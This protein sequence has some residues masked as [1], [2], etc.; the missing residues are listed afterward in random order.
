M[1]TLKKIWYSF[2]IQII[3]V[4]LKYDFLLLSVW[5]FFALLISGALFKSMGFHYLFLEPEYLGIVNFRSFFITGLAFGVFF[6]TWNMASYSLQSFRFP[7][8]A[9]LKTPF[10]HYCLNNFIIPTGFFLLYN[11]Y[12]YKINYNEEAVGTEIITFYEGLLAGFLICLFIIAPYLYF[13]NKNIRQI[14]H[15]SKIK[16]KYKT[17]STPEEMLT[18]QNDQNSWP[19]D[20]YLST[21]LL[22]RAVRRVDH[23]SQDLLKAVFRQNHLNNF[24]VQISLIVI[25]LLLGYLVEVPVF[26]FPPAFGL[27]IGGSLLVMFV[28][29][30]NYWISGWSFFVLIFSLIII[31]RLS[32]YDALFPKNKMYGIDYTIAPKEYS[33]ATINEDLTPQ[34]IKS[35]IKSGIKLLKNR[36]KNIKEKYPYDKPKMVIIGLSGGGS[37]AAYW[38]MN[39]LQKADSL[40]N[41]RLLDQTFLITGA[42]GGMFAGAYLRELYLRKEVGDPLN[43]WDPKWAENIGKDKLNALCSMFLTN[44]LL[45]PQHEF[46]Y[47]GFTYTKDRGYAFEADFNQDTNYLLNK[48]IGEYTDDEMNGLIPM[49]V[50][51]PMIINDN[52][53]LFISSQPVSYLSRPLLPGTYHSVPNI[54]TDGIEF[55]RFFD[56]YCANDILMTTALR[57]NAT[58]PIIFPPVFLPTDPPVRVMDAGMRDNFGYECVHRYVSAYQDWI[59]ENIDQVVWIEIRY[60]EKLEEIVKF[61]P[62]FIDRF[63]IPINQ[64]YDNTAQMIDFYND[65]TTTAITDILD[66]RIEKISFDL[67]PVGKKERVS[68]SFHLTDKEKREV[69]DAITNPNN[70]R[71]MIRLL[72]LL[73]D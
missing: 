39:V 38:T 22:P 37:A 3:I 31:D 55:G 16:K 23:Y 17:L 1:N 32:G 29:M 40:L 64:N 42:S 51:S 13:T 19:V 68:M 21:S 67:K 34:I 26:Q 50:I 63:S 30:I 43:I 62:G 53:S 46:E 48:S 5:I 6:L 9:A 60:R 69:Q 59:L 28:A 10:T 35:D 33:L 47:N 57:M 56:R 65:I 27:F 36:K 45:W 12:I 73:K 54:E 18:N 70:A 11:Y 52:R 14:T 72:E 49:L 58:F 24:I 44:D 15:S 66:N 41:G 25:L 8:L 4:Q 71:S 7:F 61:E 2:P 20:Y